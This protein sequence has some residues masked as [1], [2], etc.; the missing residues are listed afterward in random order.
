MDYSRME[1]AQLIEE[2]EALQEKAAELECAEAERKRE[3]EELRNAYKQLLDIIDFLPDATFVINVDKKVIAWNRA[4]EEMTGVRKEEIMGQGDYAYAIPF[5]GIRRP[6][7]IDLVLS[8]DE[9]IESRYDYIERKGDTLIAEA[10]LP[11]MYEGRGGYFWG[12]AAPLLNGEGEIAGAIE[13]IRDITERKRME[14]ERERLL[15]AEHEQRL[16]AETLAEVA[17]ALTSQVS[18]SAVLDEI[19]R[20]AQRIIPYNTANIMLL[21]GDTLHITRWQGY[22]AFGAEGLISNL[23][24]PLADFLVDA[25][26]VYLRKPVIIPDTHQD[27][28]WVVFDE[29]AW[30]KSNLVVPICL[31]DRVLGLIRLDGEA[32]GEFSA[33]DAERLQPLANAAAIAL[34][35]AQL[36][37]A[38]QQELAERK[39]AEERLRYQSYLL[40]SVSDAIISTDVHFNIKSWNKAAEIMYGWQADEVIGKEMVDAVKMEYALGQRDKLVKEFFE[41]GHWEGEVIQKRKDGMSLHILASV[42]LLTDSSGSPTGAVAVNRDITERKRAEEALRD[43]RRMLQTVLDSIPS[44]VFWKD[45]ASIY[46]GANRALL[47]TAGLKSS[48]EIVGK[49]DYDLPWGKKQ[50]DSFREDDR[51]VM[52]SGIPEYDIV[53]SYLRADGTHAWAK[54]NKVPL[55]D[56]EGNVVGVLGTSEDIT[57][58]KRAEEVL[59]ESEELFRTIVET[60]PALLMITDPKG[61]FTYISP[62]CEKFT[63]YTQEE[64]LTTQGWWV[65]EDDVSRTLELFGRVISEGIGGRDFEYRAVK[66]DGEVWYASSSWDPLIDEVGAIYGV[67]ILTFDITERKRAEKTLRESQEHYRT[68]F[69]SAPIG[70]FHSTLEGK[71]ISANPATARILGYESPDEFMA[72]V[73]RSNIAEAHYVHPEKRPAAV[74]AGLGQEGWVV[75]ENEYRRK[76]GD[77]I[78]ASLLFRTV[79]NPDGTTSHVEGFIQ[80][81][82][83]RKRAEEALRESEERFRKVFEEGPIGMVLTNRDLKFFSANPAFCQMLGY[84]AEEM[85]SKTFLDVTHPAHRDADRT[86]VQKMWQGEIPSYRTEKR[87]IAK[88]GDVRWGNLSASLIRGR[89]GEPLYALAIVEDI[90]ERKLAE[91]ALRESA[92]RLGGFMDSATDGFIL[93]DSEMNV[94]EINRAALKIFGVGRDVI[95]KNAVDVSPDVVESGRYDRYMEVMRTGKPFFADDVVPHRKFGDIYLAI[96]AFKVGDGL[97]TIVTNITERKRAE[98]ALRCRAEELA[99]LQAT[100]LEI[101]APHDLPTLLHTIVE[102]AVQLLDARGGGMYLCDPGR[103]EA[104]CVVSY[105]TPHDYT[106]TILEYGEGAAG[107]VAQTGE[108]LIIDDYRVWGRRAAVY[109]EEQPFTTV[110]SA[111]MIWQDQVTGVIHI[112]D[113][114]ESRHFTEADLALLTLFA[115]HAAIAIENTRLFEAERDQRELAEAL[116][117][118]ATTVSSTLDLDEVLDHILEQ[119]ERVVAGDAF[120]IVLIED[121]TAH[122]VRWRG[123]E[124]PEEETPPSRFEIPIARY[125]NLTKMARTGEPVLVSDTSLDPA[126]VAGVRDERWR[127]SYVGVPIRLG[128]ATVGFLGVSSSQP[129]QFGP[130]DIQR[131]EALASHAATAIGNARLYEEIQQKAEE[132][133]LLL[134]TATAASSTL[135]LDQILHTLAEKMTT[136]VDATFCRIAL[137]DKSKQ[138]LTIQAASPIRGLDWDPGL[139][140]QYALA[141][142]PWHRQVIERGEAVVLRQD[143]PSKAVSETERRIA[144]SEGTQSA[145]LVPL[146]I[147]DRILGVVSLG[148]MRGWERTPFTAN[149]VRLCHAL[150]D[151]AAITIENARLYE[152]EHAAR[153]QLS[154]LTSYLQKAREEERAYIAREI[155]DEF[156]QALTALKMDLSWLAKRLPAD[157]PSLTEKANAMSDL[158]DDTIQMVRHVATE[159]RPGLLDDLGLAAA[160]EW[161]TQE[162]AERTEIDCEL[163]VSDE[164]IAL[165]RDLATAV[166]RIFQ[167]TLTNVARHAQATE[168]Y[169]E[170]EV[171]SDELMLVVH[172]NGRGIA[173]GQVAGPGS[174]GLMGMQERARSWGGDI[175]FEGVPGQGT[176]VT[177]RVPRLNSKEGWG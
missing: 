72:V 148:E 71:I 81:I 140:R 6:M 149:R 85:S 163:Y 138:T 127:R 109:E 25:E 88:N 19:L 86:N 142:A 128:G 141:D 167:E 38:V 112:L 133:E 53:E 147:G 129:G 131:M 116:E 69:E 61:N 84:T 176:T 107:T 144:L 98:E 59:R 102:R 150:A 122:L 106:G 146:I 35:N 90:T 97:G 145:I 108:P 26:A 170:L 60:N 80:D 143:D 82:T 57:E 12:T 101:T 154:D 135:E 130:E 14:E 8:S 27:P 165:D 83:G 4:M 50:A 31:H 134:D 70:I 54:T 7:L 43:S 111:P 121:D 161:Q 169:V 49:S 23:V 62:N 160:I 33:E 48:E 164:E 96:R 125:P 104:R 17:L 76:D 21:E 51:R 18:H 113:D 174:L 63:G 139:G 100:V 42:S 126:W 156:G 89:G 10:F 40:Q 45:R 117:E 95:G 46:L 3:G 114:V 132:L 32:P 74:E 158:I 92:E 99:S 168:V 137:L 1:K 2:I 39:R 162:F 66:K 5:Y 153:Q 44:T 20:Q 115:N 124:L 87:Y 36:Y 93:F 68:I 177:V 79:R 110:L 29:T 34:E 105:N 159:L 123:G 77:V 52:E 155:H 136:S 28:R 24:Q 78:T 41:K 172:D 65:H 120:T 22:E 9:E 119:T 157:E 166:F 103:R 175:T 94:V 55:R 67:V 64:L 118:A 30:I 152:A 173:E 13:S 11:L 47:E 58:R 15:V 151:Q 91:E 37:E 56:T 16:L 75:F 73:N 171:S